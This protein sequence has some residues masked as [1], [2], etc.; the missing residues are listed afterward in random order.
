MSLTLD[1]R[2]ASGQAAELLVATRLAQQ[3]YIVSKPWL[4]QCRYDLIFEGGGAFWSVQV[5][6]A[7]WSKAGKHSYLQARLD[8]GKKRLDPQVDYFA[9]TDGERTWMVHSDELKGMTSVCLGSDNPAY[10]P[11]DKYDPELWLL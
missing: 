3:G 1:L 4:T 6:K 5:K 8:R 2:H 11:R 10:K 7:S 9:F